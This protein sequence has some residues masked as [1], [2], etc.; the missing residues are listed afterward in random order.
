MRLRDAPGRLATYSSHT[1]GR[2]PTSKE[3]NEEMFYGDHSYELARERMD[4]VIRDHERDRL[5]KQLRS[6]SKGPRSGLV[7]RGAALIM[8]LVR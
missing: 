7:A 8:T 1:A 4:T 6:A 5:A 2:C 3:R